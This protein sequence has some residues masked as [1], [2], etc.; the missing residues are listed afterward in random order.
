MLII[1]A[2][3]RTTD[4]THASLVLWQKCCIEDCGELGPDDDW[5]LGDNDGTADVY[6]LYPADWDPTEQQLEVNCT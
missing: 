3:L 2:A 5:G 4:P 1:V 6:P